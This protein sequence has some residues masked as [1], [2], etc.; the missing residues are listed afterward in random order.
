[1]NKTKISILALLMLGITPLLKPYAEFELKEDGERFYTGIV[2]L[3]KNHNRITEESEK[4]ELKR[5]LSFH[6]HFGDR[7]QGHGACIWF[8]Q[9]EKKDAFFFGEPKPKT[10]TILQKI[11]H[12]MMPKKDLLAIAVE[13]RTNAANKNVS[14]ESLD[15]IIK[16]LQIRN[17]KWNKFVETFESSQFHKLKK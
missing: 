17:E 1:M 8:T 5:L 16:E 15:T 14:T 7:A 6:D 13:A 11:Q 4:E 9:K 10:Q 2:N 12:A 3:I